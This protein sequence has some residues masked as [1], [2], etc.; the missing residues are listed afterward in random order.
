LSDH[1]C[2]VQ[3]E[4]CTH[5]MCAMLH[6]ALHIVSFVDG[7]FVGKCILTVSTE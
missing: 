4:N 3:D 5:T 6:A 2:T 7:C 1:P